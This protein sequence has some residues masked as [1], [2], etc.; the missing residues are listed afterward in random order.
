MMHHVIIAAGGSGGHVLPAQVVANELQQAGA[1]MSFAAFGLN[2]NPFFERSQWS[3]H[4]IAAAPPSP[5]FTFFTSTT[6][7]IVQALRMMRR[8]RPSLVIGFGSYHVFPVLVAASLLR[9]PTVLYAADAVPGRA[10]RLFAPFAQWTG[11]FFEE[12]V[13]KIQGTAYHV[14]FPLRSALR[15]PLTKQE[16]CLHF[17]LEHH[18][19][20]VLVLG[21]SQGSHNLNKIVPMAFAKLLPLPTVIHLAGKASDINAIATAYR[22]RTI[23]ASVHAYENAMHYAFAAADVVIARAGASTI[24][25]IEACHKPAIYIPYPRA[26]DDHQKKN[27]CLA[28]ARGRAVVIDEG[29]ATPDVIA[30][31]IQCLLEP[32][33]EKCEYQR[34]SPLAF[35]TKILQTLDEVSICRRR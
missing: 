4:D 2:E 10:I 28:A 17:G 34:K 32:C 26:M 23:K 12:A 30:H 18:L 9:I 29:N 31:A 11:C 15:S 13:T 24:A 8:T 16:G 19:P 33:P 3:F 27:A 7:G 21:G 20:T 5:S 14:D 35:I 25:E 22:Q 6:K 1:T